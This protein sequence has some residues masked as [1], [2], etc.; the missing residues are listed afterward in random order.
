MDAAA[1]SLT[2]GKLYRFRFKSKNYLGYSDFSD[3]LI[4]GLGSLPS[5]PQAPTK[6]V[7]ES[8]DTSIAMVWTPL[9]SETLEVSSYLLYM[10]D[11]LGVH[12]SIV[13]N[14]TLTEQVVTNLSPGISY[15]FYVAALNFNGQGPRS[16]K[17]MY[18]S[19][20]QPSG[21]LAPELVIST[22]TTA[23]LRWTQ[24]KDGGCPVTSF[25]VFSDLGNLAAGFVNNLEPASVQNRPYLFEHTFTFDAAL[26]GTLLRF[27]LQ[28]TNEI[29]A[30]ISEDYLQILLAG[31]PPKPQSS[32][33]KV[34]SGFADIVVE[35]PLVT[36]DGG[37]TLDAYSLEVDDGIQ[38]PYSDYYTGL[39][40]TVTV[41]TI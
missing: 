35:M 12:F 5:K 3:S 18:R 40:R 8:S 16:D 22:S 7:A 38:G 30:T 26:T 33:T 19:C 13:Y 2:A 37:T 28:A 20:V 11:G 31:V 39:N 15:T 32:A 6:V 4:V 41:G 1:E 27:K 25:N 10:D 17:A 9:S 21:V 23:Y 34:S 24:P 29:G 14:G 36:A